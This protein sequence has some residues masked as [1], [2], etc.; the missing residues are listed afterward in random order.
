MFGLARY[1]RLLL[2]FSRF[3]LTQELAF[4]GNFLIKVVVEALWL[5]IRLF[6]RD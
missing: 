2:A 1:T 4:R 5:S 6:L 3:S